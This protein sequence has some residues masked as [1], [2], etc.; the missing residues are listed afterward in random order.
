MSLAKKTFTEK[1]IRQLKANDALDI[2][3]AVENSD[4]SYRAAAVIYGIIDDKI[5]YRYTVHSHAFPR[6]PIHDSIPDGI[7]SSDRIYF[8]IRFTWPSAVS[9][10]CRS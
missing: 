7:K 1:E 2:P 3:T 5:I 4:H 8:R 10:A 9:G 6:F